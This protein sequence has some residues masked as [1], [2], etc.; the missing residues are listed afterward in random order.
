[1]CWG[2]VGETKME[3]QQKPIENNPREA[4]DPFK[5]MRLEIRRMDHNI[6]MIRGNNN[7]NPP[8]PRFTLLE[9]REPATKKQARARIHCHCEPISGYSRRYNVHLPVHFLECFFKPFI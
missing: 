8:R 1:M 9:P 5:K 2:Q 4:E 6:G 7:R 3:T